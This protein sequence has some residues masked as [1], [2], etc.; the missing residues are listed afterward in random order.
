SRARDLA[1]SRRPDHVARRRRP[2]SG[3]KLPPRD[4]NRPSPAGALLGVTSSYQ[5]G[6]LPPA[7]RPPRRG[8]VDIAADPC[9]P[10]RRVRPAR[11]QGCDRGA[12]FAWLIGAGALLHRLPGQT[13][14]KLL[15]RSQHERVRFVPVIR[16]YSV[17]TS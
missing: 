12:A 14:W 13:R 2:G 6:P 16:E 5:P 4:R 7:A 1:A 15:N 17:P 8:P 9:P 11:L 10:Y 3:T